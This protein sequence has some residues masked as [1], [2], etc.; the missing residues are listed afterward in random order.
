[1]RSFQ[2]VS[3]SRSKDLAGWA[4]PYRI[5]ALEKILKDQPLPAGTTITIEPILLPTEEEKRLFPKFSLDLYYVHIQNR[6]RSFSVSGV[7]EWGVFWYRV[8]A[9]NPQH[10]DR[11]A[12]FWGTIDRLASVAEFVASRL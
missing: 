1:V 5:V 3:S 11:D 6:E 8:D 2:K 7:S 10:P 12:I 4:I 9:G